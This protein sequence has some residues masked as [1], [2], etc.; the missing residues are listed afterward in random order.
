M[1]SP[2]VITSL[3]WNTEFTTNVSFNIFLQIKIFSIELAINMGENE[4]ST[5][6]PHVT[7]GNAAASPIV[8]YPLN[9]DTR[10]TTNISFNILL[11]N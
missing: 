5:H 8:I 7:W 2:I 6:N 11:Q 4:F 3:N 10:Y 1:A 9:L